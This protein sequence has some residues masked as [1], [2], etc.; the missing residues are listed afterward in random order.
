MYHGVETVPVNLS[1]KNVP[2]ELAERL[3][4][5]AKRNCRSIQEELTAILEESV[6][7]ARLSLDEA[8]RLL[9]ALRFKTAN[10]STAWVREL[11]DA[12]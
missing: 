4:N 1:I 11:R 10:D 7:P 5:R 3:R 9:S 6:S 12:R 2:D 8:E